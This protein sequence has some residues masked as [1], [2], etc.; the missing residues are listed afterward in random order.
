MFSC[1]V[2]MFTGRRAH[3]DPS[4]RGAPQGAPPSRPA[5]RRRDASGRPGPAPWGNFRFFRPQRRARRFEGTMGRSQWL[6]Q[7]TLPR[8]AANVDGLWLRCRLRAEARRAAAAAAAGGAA[9][10]AAALARARDA[11]G[12]R[13]LPAPCRRARYCACGGVARPSELRV[14]C[15]LTNWPATVRALRAGDTCPLGAPVQPGCLAVT[16]RL[17]PRAQVH[18][19]V[20]RP[21]SSAR[22]PLNPPL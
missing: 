8:P 15:S 11:T 12:R 6:A 9:G 3:L 2:A 19:E 18:I 13:Q 16:V 21:T 14:R 4:R 1:N 20:P 5:Q 10:G 7:L 22:W 17:A